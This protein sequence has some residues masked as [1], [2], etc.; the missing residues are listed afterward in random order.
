MPSGAGDIRA[1]GAYVEL[2]LKDSFSKQ[3]DA[4]AR[5]FQAFGKSLATVGAQ[6]VGVGVA[7]VAPLALAAKSFSSAGAHLDDVSQRTGIAVEELQALKYAAQLS[8]VSFEDL[9]KAIGKM[10]KT[11]FGA[12]EGS[13]SAVK[14][15]ASIGLTARELKSL[16]PDEQFKVIAQ[17]LGQVGEAGTRT[18]LSMEIFG[19][20][21]AS[22]T[23]LFQQS[24][25]GISSLIGQVKGSGSTFA[26]VGDG[27]DRLHAALAAAAG[28]S[29]GAQRALGLLGVTVKDLQSLSPDEQ[30]ARIAAKLAE[31]SNASVQASIAATL[32]GKGGQALV[33][34]VTNAAAAINSLRAVAE[35]SGIS[36]GDVD[37]AVKTLGQS[38]TVAAGGGH[39]AGKAL[40]DIGIT[41]KQLAGLSPAS[42]LQLVADALERV[43]DEGRRSAITLALFGK[44]GARLGPLLKASASGLS[45]LERRARSLGLVMSKEDVAAAAEFDDTLD[46]LH[47]QIQAVTN[48]IGA[49]VVNVLQPFAGQVKGIVKSV[50]DW[51]NANRGLVQVALG[52]GGALV[53]AG[54][55]TIGLGLGFSILG[56]AIGGITSALV[57]FKAI[58]STA[59]SV[60]APAI[61]LALSAFTTSFGLITRAVLAGVGVIGPALG[62]LL[63]PIGLIGAALLAAGVAWLYFSGEAG[64][65]AQ[66]VGG[67]LGTVRSSVGG[68][69]AYIKSLGK[70][71]IEYLS[72]KF[73]ELKETAVTAF[74]GISDALGAG[75]IL[76]AA[77]ILWTGLQLAWVQGTQQLQGAWIK[78]KQGFVEV[79]AA[80]FYGALEIWANVQAGLET[81]WVE[82]VAIFKTVWQD[83]TAFLGNL[84]D[85]FIG[86]FSDLWGGAV[87]LVAKGLN[88]VKGL[89]D[90]TF[91]SGAANKAAD[92]LLAQTKAARQQFEYQQ[93]IKREDARKKATDS[94]SQNRDGALDKINRDHN[95]A[96]TGLNRR[97]QETVVG[98]DKQAKDDVAA[99]EAK[100]AELQ[101]QL[102]EQAFEAGVQRIR[103][104]NQRE[105]DEKSRREKATGAA[106]SIDDI[107]AKRAAP[108]IKA[109]GAFSVDAL[110]RLGAG[111][112]VQDR[113][114]AAAEATAK[115]TKKIAD[116][117]PLAFQ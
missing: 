66:A 59:F 33:P 63:T 72:A 23:P 113:I 15:L 76:L 6:M 12:A 55:A 101:R 24:A 99:I 40:A 44:Q 111:G 7:I 89:W 47:L 52:I 13:Q 92:E 28:G 64:K 36:L 19:K 109:A 14:A 58:L 114:A 39:A 67:H 22:L 78:F 26:A 10:A 57:P 45:E 50:I 2:K 70:E 8:A 83:A 42:Q 97:E 17:R 68:A 30:F 100:R 115:N 93:A 34:I 60:V 46:D 105:A 9:E 84:W 110:Q 87:N 106:D 94:I 77:Q 98:A 20:A 69:M 116:A 107:L 35:A 49:A 38:L 54:G 96:I 61:R 103:A 82:T 85:A 21:A 73:L 108:E 79:A 32:F 75:D 4:S 91:D 31:V 48:S 41:S 71:A 37:A 65:M 80:A 16:S 86:N 53:I 81:A 117:R 18:A 3:L 29:H 102:R 5:Q 1:G 62:L 74:G 88:Y 25:G 43:D 95:D 104:E 112:Q 51:T 90:S 11:V 27:V 56:K